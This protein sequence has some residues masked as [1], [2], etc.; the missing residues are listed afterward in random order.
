MHSSTKCSPRGTEVKLVPSLQKKMADFLRHRQIITI[1]F[2]N[3]SFQS[4]TKATATTK[5]SLVTLTMTQQRDV[6]S[7]KGSKCRALSFSYTEEL[8]CNNQCKRSGSHSI[9]PGCCTYPASRSTSYL[10]LYLTLTS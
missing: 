3:G 4:R 6:L 5:C 1:P 10:V 9:Q 7:T 2:A 8:A